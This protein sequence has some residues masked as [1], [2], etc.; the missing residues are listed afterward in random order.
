MRK[1]AQAVIAAFNAGKSKSFPSIS[2]DGTTIYSYA[3]ALLTREADGRHIYN[4][5]KYSRTTSTQQTSLRMVFPFAMTVD[6][7]PRGATA[8]DLSRKAWGQVWG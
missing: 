3:T 8:K 1:N 7:L 2:T 6:G 5:T 4:D